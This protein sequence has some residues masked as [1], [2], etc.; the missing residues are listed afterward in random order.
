MKACPICQST[1]DDSV[2]FCFKDGAPLDIADDKSETI[3][4]T[5][6]LSAMLHDDIEPPDAIS[7]SN[8]PAVVDT[9]PGSSD[10]D[11]LPPEPTFGN[12]PAVDSPHDED[13]LLPPEP[14]FSNLKPV[15]VPS[16]DEAEDAKRKA[17]S[18]TVNDDPGA[19]PA[20]D[21]FMSG[22]FEPVE[23]PASLPPEEVPRDAAEVEAESSE[24]T[25][26]RDEDADAGDTIKDGLKA[27]PVKEAEKDKAKDGAAVKGK[28]KVEVSEP[29]PEPSKAPQTKPIAQSS[30]MSARREAEASDKGNSG[31]LIFMGVAALLLIGFIVMTVT[32]GGD[33]TEPDPI[34]NSASS[35]DARP[36]GLPPLKP[37]TEDPVEEPPTEDEGDASEG[38]SAAGDDG[39]A[40]GDSA[41]DGDPSN[42]SAEG[43]EGDAAEEGESKEENTES[44]DDPEVAQPEPTPEPRPEPTPAPK[45]APKTAPVPKPEPVDRAPEPPI[46]VVSEPTPATAPNPWTQPTAE[47]TPAPAVDPSNPWGAA[48]VEASSGTLI[49]SSQPGGAKVLVDRTPRGTTPVTLQLPFKDYEVRVSKDGF[50]SRTQVVKVI[51]SKPISVDMVLESLTPTQA[52]AVIIAS[53]PGGA[54]VFVDGARKGPTPLTVS[55]PVGNHEIRLEAPN[56]ATCTRTLTVTEKTR[57]AFYD[58]NTCN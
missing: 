34:A 22:A 4:A 47:A 49:V 57:N 46:A 25:A 58:L 3:A 48:T 39:M 15:S 7:L 32:G 5:E 36:D 18:S 52:M 2:D 40:E 44:A 45:T 33:K 24:P 55:M 37:A 17:A 14:T 42:E 9:L 43:D 50:A 13:D 12:L 31:L 16:D 23:E 29:K 56:L 30:V 21:G 54:T 6:T 27:A 11:L 38:G 10:E 20:D 28:A 1:Y 26:D 35:A 53:N 8:I 51:G 41:E 19:L